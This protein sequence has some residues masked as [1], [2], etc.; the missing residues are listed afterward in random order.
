MASDS[1]IQPIQVGSVEDTLRVSE[2]LLNLDMLVTPIRPP[3]VPAGS[4]RLRVTLS[5]IHT[6]EH[7]DRLVE[8]LRGCF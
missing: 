8:A 1:A 2:Q 4:S 3:T 6:R 5:A 7:I